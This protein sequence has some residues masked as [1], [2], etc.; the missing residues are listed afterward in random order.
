MVVFPWKNK[1]PSSIIS[2]GQS[3]LLRGFG[4]GTKDLRGNG[5]ENKYGKIDTVETHLLNVYFIDPYVYDM[6]SI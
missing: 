6:F 3:K 4:Y 2:P 5:L 1:Q